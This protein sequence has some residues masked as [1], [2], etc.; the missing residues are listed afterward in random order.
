MGYLLLFT[1][2]TGTLTSLK[3]GSQCRT[4]FSNIVLSGI[5]TGVFS[6]YKGEK[7]QQRAQQ[8]A[9][10]FVTAWPVWYGKE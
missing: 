6:D 3:R 1:G 7:Q 4:G 2:I 10:N 5:A 8:M 9:V